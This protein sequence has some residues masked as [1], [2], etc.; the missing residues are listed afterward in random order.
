MTATNVNDVTQTLTLIDG[1]PPVSGRPRRRP[2]PR[3]VTL[4]GSRQ[5]TLLRRTESYGSEGF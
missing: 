1:M 3:S 4:A 5:A 2:K